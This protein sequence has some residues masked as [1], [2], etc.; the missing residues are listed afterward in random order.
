MAEKNI[1]F[2]DI[3]CQEVVPYFM[4]E[5]SEAQGYIHLL[6]EQSW[7]KS[8]PPLTPKTMSSHQ[9]PLARSQ[10]DYTEFTCYP[11]T[12]L[13]LWSWLP[14]PMENSS[15]FCT[16]IWTIPG[17]RK[18]QE[19]TWRRKEH[20]PSAQVSR[21]KHSWKGQGTLLREPQNSSRKPSISYYLVLY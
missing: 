14:Y 17:M 6:E 18:K 5:E 7:I 10:V 11:L 4:N 12:L 2:L 19:L 13:I 8:P 9:S 16:N 20:L 3:F 15:L 21:N 1:R